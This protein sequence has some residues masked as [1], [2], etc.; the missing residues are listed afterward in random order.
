[1]KG[2]FVEVEIRTTPLKSQIII[3]RSALHA[4]KAYLVDDKN[5]L[6]IKAVTSRIVQGDFVVIN[7]GLAE[8]DHVIVSDISPAIEGML[9]K[10][11]ED[12]SVSDRLKMQASGKGSLR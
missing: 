4:G 3:P 8:N 2:M 6:R 7:R 12:R 1:M 5:R 11:V 10:A 9:L